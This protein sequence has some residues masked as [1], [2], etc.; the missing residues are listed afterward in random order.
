MRTSG[1]VA[2][3]LL[4]VS[5][6]P[7]PLTVTAQSRQP[8]IDMHMHVLAN[9]PRTRTGQPLPRPCWPEPCSLVGGPALEGD[10]L[11]RATLQ[12][13]DRHN[14]VLGFL[15]GAAENVYMWVA[16]APKRFVATPLV[17]DPTDVDIAALRSAYKD[18]RLQG[19]GELTNQYAGIAANDPRMEP[20]FALAEEFDVPALVHSE[21]DRR[22]EPEVPDRSGPSRI[23]RRSSPQTSATSALS[24]ERR[25]PFSRGNDLADVPLPECPCRC[26]DDNLA[27]AKGRVSQLPTPVG[28]CGLRTA[29]DV[30]LG[31]DVLARD[32]RPRHSGDRG[33]GL[34]ECGTEA[35][36]PLQQRS[37]V[38]ATGRQEQS[39]SIAHVTT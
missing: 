12:A 27:R 16:A 36:Y 9:L 5:A 30:R 19:M 29:A 10:D 32:H 15:S 26:V 24:G 39:I 34:P 14:V 35:G 18:G 6:I 8:V 4:L 38:S 11:L 13:M 1:L 3:G 33:C 28:R 17:G 31:S 20:F 22:R 2:L 7:M 21:G 37:P 23:A 25:F